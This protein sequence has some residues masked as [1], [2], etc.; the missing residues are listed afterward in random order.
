METI[1]FLLELFGSSVLLIGFGCLIGHLLKFDKF[2]DDRKKSQQLH[3]RKTD[4]SIKE[5][6]ELMQ[7]NDF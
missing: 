6:G 5:S 2:S 3:L 1:E 7:N 4:I